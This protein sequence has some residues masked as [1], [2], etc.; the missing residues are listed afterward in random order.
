MDSATDVNIHDAKTTAMQ[1][2]D[3]YIDIFF[4]QVMPS[5]TDKN[6]GWLYFYMEELLNAFKAGKTA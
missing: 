6:F 2:V 3:A 1:K 5:K 4:P